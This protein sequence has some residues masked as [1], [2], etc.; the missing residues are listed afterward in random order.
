M[1]NTSEKA[2]EKCLQFHGGPRVD[3]WREDEDRKAANVQVN[4]R[5][6][7]SC[8]ISNRKTTQVTC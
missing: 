3:I 7:E 8:I 4:L 1:K 5:R 6:W 2:T